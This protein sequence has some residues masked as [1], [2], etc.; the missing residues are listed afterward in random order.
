MAFRGKEA[1]GI[2]VEAELW[3]Y[4]Y[5]NNRRRVLRGP[6]NSSD[7]TY[8]IKIIQ[9]RSLCTV[10]VTFNQSLQRQI[11]VS[12]SCVPLVSNFVISHSSESV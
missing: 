6:W 12:M 9:Q 5:S 2:G 3:I 10:I 7:L 4:N 11:L 1:W 8:E